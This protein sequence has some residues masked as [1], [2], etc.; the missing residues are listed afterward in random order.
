ML[1]WLRAGCEPPQTALPPRP[2]A[3][4]AEQAP[5]GPSRG[6]CAQLLPMGARPRGSTVRREPCDAAAEQT[7]V[8][9]KVHG[10]V[11]GG[12]ERPILFS[13]DVALGGELSPPR[14]R[15]AASI[16]TTLTTNTHTIV[17]LERRLAVLAFPFAIISPRPPVR[18][19]GAAAPPFFPI[20]EFLL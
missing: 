9:S 10:V 6:D 3:A 2:A 15:G 14:R 18:G 11:H 4:E 20:L 13:L 1:G 12:A 19:R 17:A 5:T 16:V 8:F 7:C